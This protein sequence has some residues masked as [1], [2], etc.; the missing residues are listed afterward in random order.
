M[1]IVNYVSNFQGTVKPDIVFFGEDLPEN[2]YQYHKDM[3]QADLV[4]IM[5]TSLQVIIFFTF[6][7]PIMSRQWFSF[8]SKVDGEHRQCS[9]LK[10]TWAYNK[11]PRRILCTYNPPQDHTIPIK[12]P[13]P[14]F[15]R[16]KHVTN[17][18]S[19]KIS[20]S[21]HPKITYQ[22]KVLQTNHQHLQSGPCL[23]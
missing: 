23:D 13:K 21:Q 8:A 10:K 12:N 4:L 22:T 16:N 19:T 14:Q 9:L 11:P 20:L 5:G 18:L 15:Q 2:F 3:S 17:T 1:L 7:I 6:C